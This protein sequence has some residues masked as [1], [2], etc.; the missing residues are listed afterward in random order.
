MALNIVTKTAQNV[1]GSSLEAVMVA[2]EFFIAVVH[3]E[4]ACPFTAVAAAADRNGDQGV[5]AAVLIL[6]ILHCQRV[7]DLVR[8]IIKR[9]IIINVLNRAEIQIVQQLPNIFGS[10]NRRADAFAAPCGV[11]ICREGRHLKAQ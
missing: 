9:H 1:V 4:V 11:S 10:G 2:A 5:R 7:G 6:D 3:V 8:G